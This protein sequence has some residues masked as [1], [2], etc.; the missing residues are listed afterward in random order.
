MAI[1]VLVASVRVP[2]M[3]EAGKGQG[4]EASISTGPQEM[5]VSS[6]TSRRVA[7]S[8]V[9]PGSMKPARREYMPSGQPGERPKRTE[10]PWVTSMITT[11]SVR[12]KCWRP[13][14]GQSRRHP[15]C[16]ITEG[17]PQL[18]QKPWLRCHSKRP[19]AVAATSLSQGSRP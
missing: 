8:I 1:S 5:P 19:R 2:I 12:G 17:W 6:Q 4:C 11:G 18:A 14:A 13:Q 9:S 15:A 16:D 7:A 3:S 10:L